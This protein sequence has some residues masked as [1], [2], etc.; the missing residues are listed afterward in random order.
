M[1]YVIYINNKYF[2]VMIQYMHDNNTLGP[3]R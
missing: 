3:A 1:F 2:F